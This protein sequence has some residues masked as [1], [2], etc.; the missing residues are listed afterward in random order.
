MGLLWRGW[1]LPSILFSKR[2]WAVTTDIFTSNICS[3]L[4]THSSSLWESC[5]GGFQRLEMAS[6]HSGS[7]H[8]NILV[9]CIDCSSLI[10]HRPPARCC[11]LCRCGPWGNRG[12]P[13]PR[14]G[15]RAGQIGRAATACVLSYKWRG[16]ERGR[17]ESHRTQPG[18]QMRLVPWARMGSEH[19]GLTDGNGGH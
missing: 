10:T 17:G 11:R 19:T 6:L 12:G 18:V 1:D 16:C 3:V 2:Q 5:M 9:Q 4:L 13:Q 8:I 14:A 7:L 15:G